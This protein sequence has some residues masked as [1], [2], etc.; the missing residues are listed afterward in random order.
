MDA[1]TIQWGWFGGSPVSGPTPPPPTP[2]DDN[3]GVALPLGPRRFYWREK[4]DP[5]EQ[6]RAWA[7]RLAPEWKVSPELLKAKQEHDVHVVTRISRMTRR[8]P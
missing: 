3:D 2:S 6:L 5:W 7:R 1:L 8:R 4:A